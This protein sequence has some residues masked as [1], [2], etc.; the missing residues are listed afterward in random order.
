MP[1][2]HAA[3]DRAARLDPDAATR[4]WSRR[5][6]SALGNRCEAACQVCAPVVTA[7]IVTGPVVVPSEPA[8]EIVAPG[9]ASAPATGT[10]TLEP[11]LE[12]IPPAGEPEVPFNPTGGAAPPQA[13]PSEPLP[14]VPPGE[15]RSP[16][17]LR[18][19]RPIVVEKT[20]ARGK[21]RTLPLFLRLPAAVLDR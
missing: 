16:G 19:V 5:A 17:T 20:A 13:E 7:P 10:P 6:L 3:L 21:K 4:R 1:V 8:L 14:L 2:A 12:P 11:G 15:A 18:N 9:G